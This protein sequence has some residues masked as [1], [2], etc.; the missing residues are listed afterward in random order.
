M[1]IWGKENRTLQIDTEGRR[2]KDRV[3]LK[4][5]VTETA[6]ILLRCSHWLLS[7]YLQSIVAEGCAPNCWFL[8]SHQKGKMKKIG[9]LRQRHTSRGLANFASSCPI[10]LFSPTTQSDNS[11][12]KARPIQHSSCRSHGLEIRFPREIWFWQMTMSGADKTRRKWR[13]GPIAARG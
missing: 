5:D 1:W 13:S 9:I 3:K 6:L 10:I 2:A 8:Q 7:P 11:G 4:L 12:R